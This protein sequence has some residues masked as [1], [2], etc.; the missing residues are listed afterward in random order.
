MSTDG[1]RFRFSCADMSGA[2]FVSTATALRRAAIIYFYTTTHAY[3]HTQ[4][5]THSSVLLLSV[6]SRADDNGRVTACKADGATGALARLSRA[7]TRRTRS[8]RK[9][10]R[11]APHTFRCPASQRVPST[12]RLRLIR[13]APF[14]PRCLLARSRTRNHRELCALMRGSEGRRRG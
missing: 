3:T 9:M 8:A 11:R 2:D 5:S 10:T 13:L 7:L 12:L 14:P 4:T 6:G 1:L